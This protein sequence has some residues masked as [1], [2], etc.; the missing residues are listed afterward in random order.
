MKKKWYEVDGTKEYKEAN[1]R[2]QTAAKKATEDWKCAQ[3]KAIE[4]CLN[5]N[6]CK[7]AYQLVKDLTSEKQNRTSTIQ[8]MPGKRYSEEQKILSR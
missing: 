4:T 5:K 1:N 2:I 6:N 3:C 7:R 8:D